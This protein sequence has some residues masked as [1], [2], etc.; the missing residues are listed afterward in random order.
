VQTPIRDYLLIGD[1]H[2]AALVS[3]RGSIDWLCLPTFDS[4][5]VFAAVLD[6]KKGGSFSVVADGYETSA[7]YLSSTAI[8]ETTFTGKRSRF[9]VRDFMLPRPTEEAVAHHVVRR[10]IGDTGTST[11]VFRLDP[12]SRYAKQ[13][14]S[15]RKRSAALYAARIGERSMFLHVPR[16]AR[17]RRRNGGGILEITVTVE[18]GETTDIILEYSFESRLQFQRNDLESDTARF[19]RSWVA[20]GTYFGP[21]RDGLIR[22]AITLKLMQFYPT[23]GLIAAPTTSLPE[24]MGGER[25]W[26]YRYVWLRDA[27]FTLYAFSV[28]GH[29]EEAKKFFHFIEEVAEEISACEGEDCAVDIAVMYTIWGQRL[30]R[31]EILGHLAGHRDS[32][33]VRIGNGASG[34]RQLDIYGSL[35]DAY[36]FMWKRTGL[37]ISKRGRGVI[38]L[39]VRKIAE[40]WE[41]SDSGIWEVRGFTAPFTYGKVM[42]WVGVDRALKLADVLGVSPER[43]KEWERLRGRMEKWVWRQ[44]YDRKLGTFVQYPGTKHQDATNFL[45]VLLHFLDR[46]DPKTKRII[47]RTREELGYRDLFV[48]R[49]HAKDGLTGEEGAF[50]L[51]MCWMISALA[52]TGSLP[53]ARQLFD[54]F[55]AVLPSHGLIAEEIDPV[56]YEYLGNHPQAFSHIGYIMAAW[57]LYTY[58]EKERGAKGAKATR[59]AKRT[60]KPKSPKKPRKKGRGKRTIEK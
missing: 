56:H 40:Q 45:F 37:P 6:E 4:P 51:C 19:W 42:A 3:K 21:H 13:T 7:R 9:R 8:V 34:Q 32:K 17:V 20:K 23:G 5:S 30:Q 58:G 38:L 46:H 57:Y 59:G 26:D 60:R 1:L 18:P 14:V 10:V 39:L 15:F 31:E 35:I 11:V 2:T 41:E 47:E 16:G 54:K 28:L 49:Y 22:S 33:P 43:R 27:S 44:C 53:E 48:Y 55:T 36:Y 24:T 25:N 29:K 52:A 50:V 12:H